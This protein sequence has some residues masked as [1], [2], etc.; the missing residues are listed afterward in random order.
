WHDPSASPAPEWS[1]WRALVARTVAPFDEAPADSAASAGAGGAAAAGAAAQEQPPGAEPAAT[2]PAPDRF[3]VQFPTRAPEGMELPYFLLG[4]EDAP[5]NLW[6]WRSEPGGV[7]ETIGRGLHDQQPLDAAAQSVTGAAVFDQGAW[8]LVLRRPLVPPDTT[9]QMTFIAATPIPV[10]FF[11]WDG[12]NG[13]VQSPGSISSWVYLWLD[14]PA[15]AGVYAVPAGA[16]IL[17]ALLGVV[18]VARA[19]RRERTD[20]AGDVART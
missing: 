9:R 20:G 18:V 10:A 12:D 17:T 3:T 15:S 6:E 11:A 7:R 5:V 1:D 4:D 2:G 13:E 19:Q 16:M 8:H 14:E